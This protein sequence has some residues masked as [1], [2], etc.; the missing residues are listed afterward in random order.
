MRECNAYLAADLRTV[1]EGG[2]ILALG[3]VAHDATLRALALRPAA[4]PFSHDAS[5]PLP[6][7]RLLV[8]SYHCSRYNTNT[9][10]LTAAMFDDVFKTAAAHLR[11]TQ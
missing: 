7:E 8:D 11:A 6:G 10:R 9:G 5:H 2:V 4:F 3:R 1:P